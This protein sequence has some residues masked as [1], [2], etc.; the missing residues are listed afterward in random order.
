MIDLAIVGA[1]PAGLSAAIYGVRAG[2]TLALLEQDGY[3]GGQIA[4][5]H[6]VENYPG[7]GTITGDGLAQALRQQ[8]IDLGA[9]IRLGTVERVLDGSGVKTLL[10]DDGETLEARGVIAATGAVPRTLGVPGEREYTGA[11]VSYCALCDGAFFHGRDVLVV[12]GGDTAIE[13]GLY[14]S[15]ICRRVVI[16]LRGSAF[17]GAKSR[18]DK[19]EARENVTVLRETVLT[20]IQGTD[21]VHEVTLVREGQTQQLPVDGVFIAVGTSP[22]GQWLS[23]L[24]VVMDN[25][26]VRADETGVTNVSGLFVAGDLRTKPLRQVVTAVADGANA[27]A[28]AAAWLQ[29]K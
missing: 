2:L 3:G 23:D 20:H 16:A 10:L 27:A 22:A 11:G 12:G 15:Q 19:L 24:G 28:S 4:A 21:S 13:D 6:Q 25:G 29:E 8:A 17:R 9:D 5:A 7:V 14:L 18:A 26:Y 1:G